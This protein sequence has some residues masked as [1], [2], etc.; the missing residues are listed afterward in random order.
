MHLCVL[1]FQN[2]PTQSTPTRKHTQRHKYRRKQAEQIRYSKQQMHMQ[3]G[4]VHQTMLHVFISIVNNLILALYSSINKCALI[5]LHFSF[6]EQIF[7]HVKLKSIFTS[8]Q[9]NNSCYKE[10]LSNQPYR[11]KYCYLL[12]AQLQTLKYHDQ[13]CQ[14]LQQNKINF[15]GSVMFTITKNT[16]LL[17]TN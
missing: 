17:S 6:Q 12:S 9:H 10:N 15:M 3:T 11:E 2:P 14:H 16:V 1:H 4:R 5:F 8:H 7:F 13:Y